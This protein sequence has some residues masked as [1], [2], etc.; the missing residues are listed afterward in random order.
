MRHTFVPNKY[1]GKKHKANI[2]S[3]YIKK[4]E[5]NFSLKNIF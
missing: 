2:Y 4:Y 3:S 1:E 5:T